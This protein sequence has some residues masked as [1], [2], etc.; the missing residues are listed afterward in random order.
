MLFLQYWALYTIAASCNVT[1]KYILLDESIQSSQL[2]FSLLPGLNSSCV[3]LTHTGHDMEYP[4]KLDKYY[5]SWWLFPYM[6]FLT[7]CSHACAMIL[8][9]ET[10]IGWVTCMGIFNHQN[11]KI[12]NLHDCAIL[13]LYIQTIKILVTAINLWNAVNTSSATCTTLKL[14]S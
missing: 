5:G 2:L 8:L 11:M 10:N 13:G 3:Y 9:F 6:G 4:V 14:L 7:G 1:I 12:Q